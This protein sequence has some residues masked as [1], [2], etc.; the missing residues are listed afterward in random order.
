MHRGEAAEHGV[1]NVHH[2]GGVAVRRRSAGGGL[3]GGACHEPLRRGLRAGGGPGEG[4]C[5]PGPVPMQVMKPAQLH[6][7]GF[8]AVSA[9]AMPRAGHGPDPS[10]V[11]RGDLMSVEG[12]S[13]KTA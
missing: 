1:A 2:R 11:G 7:A 10:A 12:F 5:V 8:I 13:T 4:G 3:A 9:T 6:R